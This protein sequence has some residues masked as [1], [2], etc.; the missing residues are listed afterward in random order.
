MY[1]RTALKI[2]LFLI[3]AV[4]VA[5][6]ALA[7]GTPVSTYLNFRVSTPTQSSVVNVGQDL[8]IEVGVTGVEP[9]SWQWYFEGEPIAENG[10]SRVYTIFNAQPEDAGIYRLM[11]YVGDQL[12]MSVEVNVRVIDTSKVPASGDDSMP[13]YY[14]FAAA[15]CGVAAI[16]ALSRK[17]REA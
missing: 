14:A 13:V 7:D 10:T 15:G 3:L 2:A 5:G 11:A 8:Q 1:R 9:T 4:M 6:S 17:R 12:V 16:C